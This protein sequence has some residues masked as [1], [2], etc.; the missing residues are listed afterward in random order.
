MRPLIIAIV[1]GIA[2]VFVSRR[3]PFEGTAEILA[4]KFAMVFLPYMGFLFLLEGAEVRR[5]LDRFRY[6]RRLAGA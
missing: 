1:A 3:A 2:A 5:H 6:A 4:L